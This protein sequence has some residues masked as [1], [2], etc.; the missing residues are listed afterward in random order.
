[1]PYLELILAA[2]WVVRAVS[3][4]LAFFVLLFAALFLLPGL[5]AWYR[6]DNLVLRIRAFKKAQR[7]N[8]AAL[9]AG[10]KRLAHIWA[11]YEKTLHRQREFDPASG[12]FTLVA[13]RATVP[14]GTIFT[15]EAL[16]D[17]RIRTEFFKHLPG[18]CT[19]IGIIGTFA[20]LIDGLRAFHIADDPTVVRTS[21]EFLLRGVFQAFLVSAG[22]ITLA[23]AI[24]FV[25]KFLV[26]TLYRKVEEITFELDSS[27][28][29]GVGEEYL[30]RL[31]N[32]SEGSADRIEAL[33]ATLVQDLKAALTEISAREISAQAAAHE[34]LA[35]Q[36]SESLRTELIGPIWRIAASLEGTPRE[37][38]EGNRAISPQGTEALAALPDMLERLLDKQTRV[39]GDALGTVTGQ[40]QAIASDIGGTVRDL[41]AALREQGAQVNAVHLGAES[42]MSSL[43]GEMQRRIEAQGAQSQDSVARITDAAAAIQAAASDFTRAAGGVTTVLQGS[44]ALTE[45]LSDAALAVSSSSTALQAVVRDQ[46]GTRD[47]LAAM[48]EQLRASVEHARRETS[49]SGDALQ[50]IDAAAQALGR[51]SVDVEA[52]LDRIGDVLERSHGAF[53]SGVQK[54]VDGIY[55]DFYGKLSEATQLLTEGVAELAGA[56]DRPANRP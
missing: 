41:T 39:I 43:T 52:F 17:S 54:T 30:E 48:L 40:M 24:T 12:Q 19:G 45:R 34:E 6:Y 47:S 22:A 38:G 2:P 37:A 4:V 8:P 53:A 1:M 33:K 16:V 44:T 7:S 36:L 29:A 28:Q 15:Q 32:A 10:D 5:T 26:T 18:L 14:A 25:E 51:A 9:F 11:E 27:F 42:R 13:L 20:G 31:V 23:M 35:R 21:L 46:A 50:R 56:L 55:N 3:A 49:L